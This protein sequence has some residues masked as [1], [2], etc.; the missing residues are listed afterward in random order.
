MTSGAARPAPSRE[1]VRQRLAEE[2]ARRDHR[3]GASEP[4]DR[5]VAQ[6]AAHRVADQQRAAR[7]PRPPPPRRASRRGSCASGTGAA[8]D[9][10]VEFIGV[11]TPQPSA[12]HLVSHGKPLR[13]ARAVRDDDE[14]RLPCL[15]QVEQ[16]SATASAELRSRLPV[17]SSQSSTARVADQRARDRGALLLPARQFAGPVI[18]AISRPTW[19]RISRARRSSS[20]AL[21]SAAG[22][23]S[24]GVSTFS[25]TE[26]CGSRE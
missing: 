26:H 25:S 2:P 16:K 11:R 5:D 7:A 6:A 23:A 1:I 22:A 13:Q 17:G 14:D 19:P 20:A 21:P 12:I 15:V 4:S 3:L 24:V 8:K 10:R 9:R 18:E